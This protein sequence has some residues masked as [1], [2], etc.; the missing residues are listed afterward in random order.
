MK[1]WRIRKRIIK[2]RYTI[3]I[4]GVDESKL[5]DFLREHEQI[6]DCCQ[7]VYGIT[8]VLDEEN[9]KK[10]VLQVKGTETELEAIEN[11]LERKNLK[12][13]VLRC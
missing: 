13:E 8:D 4:N 1:S 6:E 3:P 12:F 9:P 10:C 7:D 5:K 2:Q 11:V